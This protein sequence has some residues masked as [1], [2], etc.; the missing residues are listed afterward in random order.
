MS[1]G[2]CTAQARR[3]LTPKRVPGFERGLTTTGKIAGRC[4]LP[5]ASHL[6]HQGGAEAPQK[7]GMPYIRAADF[8]ANVLGVTLRF[9]SLLPPQNP[10][11]VRAAIARGLQRLTA[12]LSGN[13]SR[14][15][16]RTPMVL[17]RDMCVLGACTI[18]GAKP[19]PARFGFS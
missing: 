10:P 12:R 9:F 7:A 14:T 1:A 2:G 11:C 6:A 13:Y 3:G 15:L 17:G 19:P 16:W 18:G 4:R 5:A 8:F